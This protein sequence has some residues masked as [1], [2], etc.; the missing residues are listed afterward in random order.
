MRVTIGTESLQP[1]KS[2][3]ARA[4]STNHGREL[5][6]PPVP[7]KSTILTCVRGLLILCAQGVLEKYYGL[8]LGLIPTRPEGPELG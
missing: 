4:C 7:T 8:H 5:A 2:L 6:Q 3:L 1:T